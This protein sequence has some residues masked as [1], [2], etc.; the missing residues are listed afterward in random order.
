MIVAP[1]PRKPAFSA[2]PSFYLTK[3]DQ[4]DACHELRQILASAVVPGPSIPRTNNPL[5]Q[6]STFSVVRPQFLS[7]QRRSHSV[8]QHHLTTMM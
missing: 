5:P 8:G 1:C 3:G 4:Q 6:D 7:R 2:S